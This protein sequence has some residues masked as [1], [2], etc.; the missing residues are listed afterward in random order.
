MI[1]LFT[2]ENDISLFEGDYFYNGVEYYNLTNNTL[3][4]LQ[5]GE[6]GMS[7]TEVEYKI[8]ETYNT[9]TVEINDVLHLKCELEKHVML[10]II[11]NL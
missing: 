4:V 11:N 5:F 1:Y 8:T 6:S 9:I 3:Y 7:H 2:A 10:K